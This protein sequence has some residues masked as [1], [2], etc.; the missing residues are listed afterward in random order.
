MGPSYAGILGPI[1]FLTMLI[2]GVVKGSSV[3]GV[4]ISS[5]ASLLIFAAIGYVIGR[6][7]EHIVLEAVRQRFDHDLKTREKSPSGGMR[8]Q[9][10]SG[11]N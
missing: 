6:I 5:A 8:V 2:R 7:A 3:D 11:G 1:A 9:T 4:L 10:A